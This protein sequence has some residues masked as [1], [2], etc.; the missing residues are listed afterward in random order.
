MIFYYEMRIKKYVITGSSLCRFSGPNICY[1]RRSML[2]IQKPELWQVW[3]AVCLY[4]C[5][6]RYI[7]RLEKKVFDKYENIVFM[8]EGPI[9]N[10]IEKIILPPLP[11]GRPWQKLFYWISLNN[12]EMLVFMFQSPISN[13]KENRNVSNFI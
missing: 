13:N 6:Q 4:E 9:S 10:N 12:T 3:R 11:L 7:C 2:L 8:F 1:K 5:F